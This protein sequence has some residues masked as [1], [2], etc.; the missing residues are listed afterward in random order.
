[1]HVTKL[2]FQGNSL[3]G[4]YILPLS[5]IVLVGPEVPE[6]SYKEL[7]E[8][9]QAPVHPITIAGT[10]LIGIFAITDGTILLVPSIIFDHEKE[11]LEKLGVAYKIITSSLTCLGNNIV[12]SKKGILVN[13]SYEDAVI[14]QLSEI[15]SLPI[16]SMTLDDIPTIG[17]FIVHN[18]S[19]AL[20]S[21]D[22]S[23]EDIAMLEDFLGLQIGTG[24][25]N[26]GSTQVRS[27]LAVNEK[28][29]VIG[30]MSGGPEVVNADEVLGFLSNNG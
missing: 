16:K 22:F 2:S 8:I 6:T 4:L 17:S 11:A 20:V 14:S 7:E 5:N 13:P 21:H 3:V 18:N 23:D 26:L 28:G 30:E 15:F 1:M 19:Y 12:L 10:G 9:F 25:V 27:G 29:F 24:T